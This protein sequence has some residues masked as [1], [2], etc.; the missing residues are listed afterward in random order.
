MSAELDDQVTL[1]R[2][3]MVRRAGIS[4]AEVDE[5]E[6][7]LRDHVDT[8]VG[9]GLAEDEAFLV[10][11]KRLG[12]QHDIA[13]EFARENSQRL[14]K[15][16]VLDSG[17]TEPDGRK[18]AGGWVP[19]V[20]FALLS[21]ALISAPKL[22]GLSVADDPEFY[23]RNVTVL[24][25]GGV[26]AYLLWRYRTGTAMVVATAAAYVVVAVAA[27][28]YTLEDGGDALPMTALHV[29][30]A[31]WL[32][33]GVAYVGLR[34]RSV[35]GRMDFV[36]FTGEWFVYMAL[37]QAGG[38]VLAGIVGVVPE[39]VGLDSEDFLAEWLAP[40]GFAAATV[41]AT[42]LVEAKKGVVENM[43]PVLARV[44]TPL[45]TV[46]FLGLLAVILASGRVSTLDRDLLI[47]CDGILVVAVGLVLYNLTARGHDERAG[48]FDWLQLALVASALALDA[49]ALANIVIRVEDDGWTFNRAVVLGANLILL[50]NLAVSAWLL[51][52]LTRGRAG[53]VS[54]LERWQTALL[55]VYGAWA[56]IVV[57]VLPPVFGL[58]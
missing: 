47:I 28:I 37:L 13:H 52:R 10:A 31:M 55:P 49:L 1:W 54:A 42:W 36:R 50:I 19:A 32:A 14:W 40:C 22:F 15:Q 17:E 23:L 25:L 2:A 4:T 29:P 3:H 30:I 12:S 51:I 27:N 58:T 16:L 44:F 11:V 6:D 35:A 18:G 38:L 48:W 26:I 41:I 39:T 57:V 9:V 53:A 34:W 24:S 46:T 5:L 33:V 56:L 21:A 7:H 8:L 20:L 43:A 45:F